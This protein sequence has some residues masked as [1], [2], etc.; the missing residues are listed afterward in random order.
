MKKLILITLASVL[1]ISCTKNLPQAVEQPGESILTINLTGASFDS[2]S[3][4]SGHGLQAD[5]NYINTLDVFIF[6]AA[7]ELAG[8][9][10]IYKRF[11]AADG[12]NNLQLK[13]TTGNKN[14]YAVANAHCDW[15][16]VNTLT[17]FKAA[18]SQLQKDDLR[19]FT[20]SGNLDVTLQAT[21]SV[22]ISISRLVGRI[23]LNSIKTAFAGTPYEG[24]KL[25]NVKVFLLNVHGVKNIH[26][27]NITTPVLLNSKA[28][29]GTDVNGCTMLGML[30]DAVTPQVDDAGYR[31]PHY[32]YAYENTLETETADNRY[33]RLVIQADLNG[34]TYYYPV[35]INQE[36]YGYVAANG[37]KGLKRNTAYEI[38]VTIMR[39]GSTDPDKPLQ[40]G[41]LNVS[42]TVQN[43]V[44][45][46]VANPEF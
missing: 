35:N 20:M 18:Q 4:G 40:Y 33:T 2:K 45:T 21:T 22:N 36:G 38:N 46:P 41:T 17:A 7:G 29:S 39:P 24:S 27:G 42:L 23:K 3:T 16:G 34:K 32:F 12:I 15:K 13:T 14:I 9:L 10:D 11:T 37:H 1:T 30:Y 28:L 31:T 8:T 5:D 25:S 6:H 19:N 43:W 26:D 44:V